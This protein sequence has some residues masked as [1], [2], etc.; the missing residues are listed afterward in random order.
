M[1]VTT[2]ANTNPMYKMAYMYRKDEFTGRFRIVSA[3]SG[4]EYFPDPWPMLSGVGITDD[5]AVAMSQTGRFVLRV[6]MARLVVYEWSGGGMTMTWKR[7]CQITAPDGYTFRTS[8]L[9]HYIHVT[10]LALASTPSSWS[11]RIKHQKRQKH[12]N[13]DCLH[14]KHCMP[15]ARSPH[16]KCDDTEDRGASSHV[17]PSADRA[18][19]LANGVVARCKL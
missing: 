15:P 9:M 11:T 17:M 12:Q 10:M 4:G 3:I 8:E 7:R 5:N 18:L 19:A 1:V 13:H 16:C 14:S 6:E 2:A